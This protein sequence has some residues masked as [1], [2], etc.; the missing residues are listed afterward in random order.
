[1]IAI[2]DVLLSDDIVKAK[3]V[4]NLDACQGACCWEGEWGAPLLEEELAIIESVWDKVAPLL[5]EKHRKEVEKRGFGVYYGEEGE[6]KVLGT[7]LVKKGPCAYLIWDGKS[8][9]KCAFEVAHAQGIID[10][11]KPISCHLYPIRVRHLKN[12]TEA[13]N[14][15]KW[16]IC[17]P[18]CKNGKKLDVPLYKF[19]K[20]AIVRAKGEEF[21][22]QLEAC[23]QATE[24]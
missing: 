16:N 2:D 24:E 4:C 23:A 7:P 18:A 12:G 11:P 17:A 8:T 13:S 19:L 6:E 9:A 3:F 22:A 21:Y 20:N 10:W 5:S 15:N 1:M 14:Y